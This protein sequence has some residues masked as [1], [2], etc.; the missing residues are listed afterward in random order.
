[1]INDNLAAIRQ[2]DTCT[3]ANAIERFGVRLRNE[4]YT[5]PGLRCFTSTHAK[6]IGF[7]ATC[8][9]RLADPP[10][11][12]QS[13]LDR[14]DWW[15]GIER[16]A[17]PRIVVIE[18]IDPEPI[19][20]S[21]IGEVH[22]A[23]LQAFRCVG[24]ITNGAARDIP[25]VAQLGFEL[26]ARKAAVSHSYMHLVDY[27]EDVGILGLKVRCGDLIFAD[28]HGVLSI[29]NEI[30]TELP[31]IAAEITAQEQRIVDLCRSP[32]FSLE[33]LQKAIERNQ[34]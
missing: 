34:I 24:A 17:T 22:A 5:L 14:T 1:M 26:F 29:P 25:A 28:C 21:C 8:H 11:T 13:F 33:N 3:I 30:A 4:G 20:G 19:V 16:V 6:I 2:Y 10:I 23:I 12:G 18:D 31:A 27:G 9:V 7:A 15:V 32:E